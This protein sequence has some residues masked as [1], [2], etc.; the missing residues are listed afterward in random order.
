[1][2]P[3]NKQADPRDLFF[4]QMLVRG[5]ER[6]LRP[7]MRGVTKSDAEAGYSPAAQGDRGTTKQMRS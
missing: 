5:V 7:Q 6:I 3:L 4:K 1:M 2:K